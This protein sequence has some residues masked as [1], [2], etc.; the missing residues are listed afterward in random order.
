MTGQGPSF[1]EYE[2]QIKMRLKF[3]L[4]LLIITGPGM[5]QTIGNYQS[6]FSKNGSE[7]S[8]TTTNGT[9]KIEVCTPRMFRVRASWDRQ[10][11]NNEPWMVVK[12]DWDPVNVTT[13]QS[14][15]FFTIQTSSLKI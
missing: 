4:A 5:S 10:F 13:T 8:F 12:Y 1:N 11:E 3:L 15:K 14:T 6:G 2:Y 9:V 7:F